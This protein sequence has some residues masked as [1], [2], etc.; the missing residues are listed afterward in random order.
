MAKFVPTYDLYG[1]Q[2]SEK[3]DFWVHCETIASRSRTHRWEIRLH[4]HDVFQ[5]F[6]YIRAGSGDA[7]FDT[8]VVA[9]APPC[10][11]CLPPRTSHGFRFSRDIDGYVL[12]VAADRLLPLTGLV[13]PPGD[14][15]S[16][17]RV[18]SLNDK[19]ETAYM[20][21]TVA[22]IFEEFERPRSDSGSLIEAHLRTM[23]L[24]LNRLADADS[25]SPARPATLLRMQALEDL[26][27]RNYRDHWRARDYAK[28]LHLT[29]THLNRLARAHTGL[30]VHDLVMNRLMDEARRSLV[31]T[32]ASIHSIAEQLGFTDAAYFIRCF[33][34][35]TGMT[36]RQFR[37]EESR[38]LAENLG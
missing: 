17:P 32:A 6:L 31:F 3:A 11:V 25:G 26:I 20:D 27:A 5:Q 36:P 29:P 4:R 23:V 38:R 21:A 12:T 15:L 7:I 34:N 13:R 9:L 1:E 19:N 28:A 33:R 30:T 18:I 2:G 35:R 16:L 22:R 37:D 24:M 10:F 14:W 8:D